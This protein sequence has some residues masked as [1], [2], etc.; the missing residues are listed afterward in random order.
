M[1]R[2]L[3]EIVA[4][5]SDLRKQINADTLRHI[6]VQTN[7]KDIP[8]ITRSSKEKYVS[9]RNLDILYKFFLLSIKSKF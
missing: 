5:S 8:Q 4:K 2:R 7:Q 3:D 1:P 9:K 6:I